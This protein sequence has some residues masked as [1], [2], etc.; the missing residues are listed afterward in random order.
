MRAI[1][2]T[3]LILLLSLAALDAIMTKSKI[4]A[5]ILGTILMLLATGCADLPAVGSADSPG[6][7]GDAVEATDYRSSELR[8]HAAVAS[9]TGGRSGRL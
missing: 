3:L 5:A 1:A 8:I 2:L 7:G 4:K 9:S 6:N